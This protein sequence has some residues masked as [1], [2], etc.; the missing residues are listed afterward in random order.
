VSPPG[1]LARPAQEIAGI[2]INIHIQLGR[3]QALQQQGGKKEKMRREGSVKSS[4]ETTQNSYI[5]MIKIS[6]VNLSGFLSHKVRG[7]GF[8]FKIHFITDN[9]P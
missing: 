3:L 5:K 1:A 7:W 8:F 2:K 9:L 6:C 4:K